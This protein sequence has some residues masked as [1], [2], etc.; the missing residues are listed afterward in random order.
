MLLC[1]HLIYTLFS[2][3]KNYLSGEQLFRIVDAILDKFKCCRLYTGNTTKSFESCNPRLVIRPS[4]HHQCNCCWIFICTFCKKSTAL[5]F[6]FLRIT[7]II[8]CQEHKFSS[9]KINSSPRASNFTRINIFIW[10]IC[11]VNFQYISVKACFRSKTF[12][13]MQKIMNIQYI[14]YICEFYFSRNQ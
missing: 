13:K 3:L 12:I 11:R 6:S 1:H 2:F 8:R 9:H 7:I 4:Y 10:D 5:G 14:W